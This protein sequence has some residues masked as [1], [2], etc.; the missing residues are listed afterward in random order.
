MED[1]SKLNFVCGVNKNCPANYE[2]TGIV[3]DYFDTFAIPD[4]KN[5]TCCRYCNS[6]LFEEKT[7]Q[8]IIQVKK[9]KHQQKVALLIISILGIVTFFVLYF[10]KIV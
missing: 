6:V 9:R 10:L 2:K 5:E 4:K 7:Y 1:I 3:F 8:N